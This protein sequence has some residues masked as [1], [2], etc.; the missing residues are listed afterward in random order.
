MKLDRKEF[1]RTA[2]VMAGAGFGLSRVASCGGSDGPSST[3]GGAGSSGG[4]NACDEHP[5]QDTIGTNHGHELTVSQADVTAGAL[6]MYSIQGTAAHDHTVTLSPN[7]FSTLKSGATVMLTSSNN[8][9]HTHA[10][11]IRCA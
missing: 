8:A 9:G 11:T 7:N 2:L 4:G 5:P 3:T 1:I 10:I 6:K